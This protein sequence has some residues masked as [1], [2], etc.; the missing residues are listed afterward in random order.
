MCKILKYSQNTIGAVKVLSNYIVQGPQNMKIIGAVD[1]YSEY[2]RFLSSMI[3]P[4]IVESE[5]E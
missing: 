4:T 1:K 3:F 5:F 2:V